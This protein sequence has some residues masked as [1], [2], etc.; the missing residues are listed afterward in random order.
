MIT[1]LIGWRMEPTD[2]VALAAIWVLAAAALAPL[3]G[4]HLARQRRRHHR[5]TLEHEQPLVYRPPRD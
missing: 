3:V 5:P 4:K 1:A 2:W